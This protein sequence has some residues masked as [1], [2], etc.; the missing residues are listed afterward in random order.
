MCGALAVMDADRADR[1]NQ[2][3]EPGV[4]RF[5]VAA[6]HARERVTLSDLVSKK[7]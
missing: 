2:T 5:P 7:G 6:E 4:F 1:Q 3:P